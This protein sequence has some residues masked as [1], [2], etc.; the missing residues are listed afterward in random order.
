MHIRSGITASTALLTA[1]CLIALGCSDRGGEPP[2]VFNPDTGWCWFQDERAI[3][4]GGQLLLSGVSTEGDVTV[5]SHDVESGENEVFV[6]HDTL[7]ANDHAAPALLVLSDGRY[8][9]VYSRH[10]GDSTFWRIT[11]RPGDISSW[12]PEERFDNGARTTYSN[13]YRLASEGA[14]GRIYN[15]TRTRGWDPNFIFSDDQASSWAYGGRLIDG[16]GSEQ[17]PYVRYAGNGIDEIHFIATEQHPRDHPNSIYHGYV[18]GGKSY[19]SDGAVVDEDIFDEDAPPAAA[20]TRVFHG[21]VDNVAWTSDIELDADGRP[22]V[23]YSVTKDRIEPE[24]GGMDHR[25]RYARWAGEAWHDYEIAYAG[26]RLYPGEDAYTGLV[27]LHPSTPDVVFISTNVDPT[28]GEP[29]SVDGVQR[30]EIFKGVTGDGG[31]TWEWTATTTNSAQ[32]NLRPIVAASGD[33][34]AVAWLRGDYR[35]Y[36]DYDQAAVGLVYDALPD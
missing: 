17:R 11:E 7:E 12:R 31:A 32:D 33:A 21:D 30:Y 8:L 36:T 19:R 35:S 25:Y 22:Y 23:A 24:K 20:F 14:V 27:A 9:A 18:S 34:W 3:I 10:N 26:T 2:V 5:T 6:L 28:G 13:L 16:G 4:S 29:I 1:A 15:F